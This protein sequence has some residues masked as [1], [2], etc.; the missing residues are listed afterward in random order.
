MISKKN[1]LIIQTS[2]PHSAS[3]FLVNALHGLIE[4]MKDTKISFLFHKNSNINFNNIDIAI[5]KTHN[6]NI[7]ELISEYKDKYELYFVCSERDNE[8]IYIDNKYKSYNN[9]IVFDFNELNETQDNTLPIIIDNIYNKL[10]KL[11]SKHNFIKLNKE[12]GIT[13][14]KN[15]NKRY[16]EIK[17]KSFDY[18][19]PFFEIHGSHRNRINV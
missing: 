7:D 8:Y 16:Q 12:T 5:I 4:Q 18:V 17:N 2:P 13:R 11:L 15:M 1:I 3:T 9:V 19:D 14:I 10:C 6:T